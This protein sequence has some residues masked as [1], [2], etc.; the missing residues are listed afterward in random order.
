MKNVNPL[1][2]QHAALAS[3]LL[4]VLLLTGYLMGPSVMVSTPMS[5]GQLV[6][7]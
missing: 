5:V 7:I 4:V 1:L 6:D 3:A 2:W